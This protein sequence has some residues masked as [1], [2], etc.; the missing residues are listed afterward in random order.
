MPG[1]INAVFFT[2]SHVGTRWEHRIE[3]RTE[4]QRGAVS[5]SGT[6]TNNVA[7]R[8]N[9]HICK[10]QLPKASDQ[11]LSASFFM[12]RRCFNFRDSDLIRQRE[13]FVAQN[14]FKS[15]LDRRASR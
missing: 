2:H 14:R 12:K 11:I 15:F 9:G 10:T 8:I 4:H 5:R 3:M 13:L 1:A 6:A 7:F